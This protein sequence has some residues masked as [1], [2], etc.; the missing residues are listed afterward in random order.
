L[1]LPAKI[2]QK[3]KHSLFVPEKLAEITEIENPVSESPIQPENN[4]KNEYNYNTIN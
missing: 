4:K 1:F 2:P 3:T